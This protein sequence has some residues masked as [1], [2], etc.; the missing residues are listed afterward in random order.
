[1]GS[2]GS[3]EIQRARQKSTYPRPVPVHDPRGGSLGGSEEIA[4]SLSKLGGSESLAKLLQNAE[5]AVSLDVTFSARSSIISQPLLIMNMT[6]QAV[7]A[8]VNRLFLA[9]VTITV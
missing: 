2:T 6:S 4:D 9:V 8:N 1:M 7:I 5:T 3:L